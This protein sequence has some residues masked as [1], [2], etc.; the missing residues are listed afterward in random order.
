MSVAALSAER[1]YVFAH[2]TTGPSENRA[3]IYLQ[4]DGT[5]TT[6]MGDQMTVDSGSILELDTWYY[7]A[8]TWDG[9]EVTGYLNGSADFGP[10]AYA[11]LNVLGTVTSM[12]WNGTIQFLNGTL[13]E[14]RLSAVHRPAGWFAA[15]NLSLTDAF[16]TFGLIEPVP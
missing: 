10:T 6:G 5:F 12:S 1:G 14:L 9:T 4:A 3:Y 16:I 13:D 15:Q 7:L 2:F 8:I 11:N